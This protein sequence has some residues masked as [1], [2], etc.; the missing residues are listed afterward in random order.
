MKMI[1]RK[2]EMT[3]H[4]S[5][6]SFSIERALAGFP[7]RQRVPMCGHNRAAEEEIGGHARGV[8]SL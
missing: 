4:Q 8:T 7:Q 5:V 3:L 1:K 6:I 2:G